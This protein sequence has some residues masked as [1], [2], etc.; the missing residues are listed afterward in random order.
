M[1]FAVCLCIK[2]GVLEFM[3]F[4]VYG[5]AVYGMWSLW[6]SGFTVLGWM[7]F[8]IYGLC[9]IVS[10]K[11]G[12]LLVLVFMGSIFCVCNDYRGIGGYQMMVDVMYGIV[13]QC[14]WKINK[15]LR[16]INHYGWSL[17][18][19]LGKVS[20]VLEYFKIKFLLLWCSFVSWHKWAQI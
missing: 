7:D 8:E 5:S 3:G 19:Y 10:Y 18:I 16:G 13:V 6:V 20:L 12:G 9:R 4:G 17:W 1:G 15:L 2:F 11:F 14:D